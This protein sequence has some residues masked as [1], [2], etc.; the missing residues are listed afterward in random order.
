MTNAALK[1][2]LLVISTL[3]AGAALLATGCPSPSQSGSGMN[4]SQPKGEDP[5]TTYAVQRPIVDEGASD[6]TASDDGPADVTDTA[7]AAA[8][9]NGA[10]AA[11]QSDP[12][13]GDKEYPPFFENWPKP[14]LTLYFTG[15]Q[16]GYIEPCGCTGLANQKGGLSRRHVFYEQLAEKGWNPV[17]IDIGNQVR[18]FG[19]QPEIKFQ[20]TV[21]GMKKIGYEAIAFGPD[22]LRMSYGELL[23]A[24]IVGDDGKPAPFVSANVK[25]LDDQPPSYRVIEAGGKRIGITAIL[26]KE[27]QRSVASEEIKITDAD[28]ALAK[29]VPAL[30]D[31]KC[32]IYILLSHASGDE[33]KRLGAKFPLFDLVVTAGSAGE[34]SHR[35]EEIEGSKGKIVEIGTKGMYISAVGVFD[36]KQTPFRLQRAPLD[37]RFGDS[38]EMLKLM[39]AYQQQ[40]EAVGLAGLAIKP[41]PHPSGRKF[42][43]SQVCADCHD[44]EYEI[45]QKTPHAHA[46]DSIVHP[47]ERSEIARHHDPE[48]LSCHVTGWNPQE[49]YPYESGYLSLDKSK[50]LLQ[51]GCE[52]CH[53]PG[54]DHVAAENGEL[55]DEEKHRREM[56][57]TLD[58]ARD[59]CLKCHDL[60]NSPAFHEQGAFEKYWERVK[61]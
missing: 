6:S 3:L 26:G 16:H 17:A 57:L 15:R 14:L 46:T 34:P 19:R 18:R 7:V 33:S 20:S 44:R 43:G 13:D 51:M 55:G 5:A 21:T 38:K 60:D 54:S 9:F 50:N 28:E 23:S 48:C 41:L 49:H 58:T 24:A 37:G 47:A 30:R 31:E 59:T 1:R 32:D 27:E 42:V 39:A 29:V 53:G 22:D 8:P 35:L 52:N 61:H 40:L 2:N 10:Y 25:I 45:W 36:D 12:K 56:I 4:D 11:A